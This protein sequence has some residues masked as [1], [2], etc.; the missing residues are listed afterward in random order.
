MPLCC[1]PST[2]WAWL[3]GPWAHLGQGG[4]RRREEEHRAGV[5]CPQVMEKH[6]TET[7]GLLCLGCC[8]THTNTRDQALVFLKEG[9][10]DP[11]F[12]SQILLQLP[13]SLGQI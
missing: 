4:R 9:K 6:F 13:T 7:E 11:Q 2:G 12:F 8:K 1:C 3:C 10:P 5:S